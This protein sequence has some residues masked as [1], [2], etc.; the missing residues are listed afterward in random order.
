MLVNIVAYPFR[1][2]FLE[3]SDDVLIFDSSTRH[4]KEKRH[5]VPLKQHRK[6]T[7]V[8]PPPRR[9]NSSPY[10]RVAGS[11]DDHLSITSA[12]SVTWRLDYY[13]MVSPQVCSRGNVEWL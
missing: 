2:H 9:S 11:E 7:T 13:K 1:E 3:A 5:S 10:V 4:L 12:D 8:R 6:D